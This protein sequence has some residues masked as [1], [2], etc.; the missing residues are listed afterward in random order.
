MQPLIYLAGPEVFLPDAVDLG[1]KK[2]AICRKHGFRGLFPLDAELKLRDRDDENGPADDKSADWALSEAIYDANCRA[3]EEAGFL[4]ANMTPFR[5]PS[6]DVGTAFEMGYAKALGKPV[7]GYSNNGDGYLQRVREWDG[8]SALD[9]DL[10]EPRD[11]NGL[12]IEKFGLSD[13]LMLIHCIEGGGTNIVI[14]HNTEI[15]PY[16]DLT[17]F[18]AC[19]EM[20]ARIL[21]ADCSPQTSAIG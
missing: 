13:N 15:D 6:M 11:A 20:A 17:A 19:V 4:I 21:E 2:G 5:G 12:L 18:E 9:E 16:R 7:L 8:Q 3:I 10:G 1:L 14:N